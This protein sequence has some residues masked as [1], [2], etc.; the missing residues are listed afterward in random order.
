MIII[1]KPGTN[2]WLQ[3]V[4]SSALAIQK[5]GTD[6]EACALTTI[7]LSLLFECVFIAAISEYLP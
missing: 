7:K 4:K 6:T 3:K 1:W 2:K 5:I